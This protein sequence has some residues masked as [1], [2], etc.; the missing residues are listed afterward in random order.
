TFMAPE[1]QLQ[2]RAHAKLRHVSLASG[3]LAPPYCAAACHRLSP[4]KSCNRY[5]AATCAMANLYQL[6][7]SLPQ[8]LQRLPPELTDPVEKMLDRERAE[9]NAFKICFYSV[10]RV[11]SRARPKTLSQKIDFFKM[12][13][14]IMMREHFPKPIGVQSRV[15][16]S[17]GE[18]VAVRQTSLPL[19]YPASSAIIMHSTAERIS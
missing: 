13:M 7:T 3:D 12:L 16:R 9:T 11:W 8:T 17:G 1:L 2:C 14:T 10:S 19:S 6:P 4:R 18:P 15:C 5:T